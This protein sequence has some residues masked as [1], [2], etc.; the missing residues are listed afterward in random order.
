MELG[1]FADAPNQKTVFGQWDG[2]VK[3]VFFLVCVVVAAFVQRWWAALLLLVFALGVYRSLRLPWKPFL[4]RMAMP[5]GIAWLV[6][7]SVLFTT[8][9]TPLFV[10]M[11]HPVFLQAY[12][13]G[14]EYGFLLLLRI[15]AAVSLASV[16]AFSTP[17]IEILETLRLLKLPNIMVD[18]AGLMARYVFIL[19]ETAHR[20]HRAQVSR[21]V[22]R[23]RWKE[24]VI[25]TGAVAGR[26]L[27]ESFDRSMRIYQAMLA[28]G[29][30]DEQRPTPYYTSAISAKNLRMCCVWAVVPLAAVLLN[31]IP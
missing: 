27:L 1:L 10:L 6:F 15:M 30:N 25:N 23:L 2:R 13:E 4:F 31:F 9:H 5:F 22:R 18:L 8:G 7:L 12:K 3:T 26:I 24:Q 21:T 19:E 28:R 17:M 14:L 20:M 11:R 29:Y 16:L